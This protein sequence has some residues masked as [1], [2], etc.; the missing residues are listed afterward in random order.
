MSTCFHIGEEC[1]ERVEWSLRYSFRYEL[2]H[3][4]EKTGFEIIRLWG[5]YARHEFGEATG[6]LFVVARKPPDADMTVVQ[7]MRAE[8]ALP[9]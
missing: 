7:L 6:R 3:L 1:R 2:E 5:D 9:L 8:V 4:L